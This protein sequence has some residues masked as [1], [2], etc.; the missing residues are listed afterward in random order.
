MLSS[1]SS[2]GGIVA[3][4]DFFVDMKILEWLCVERRSAMWCWS[5]KELNSVR[6]KIT[7]I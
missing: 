6:G 5:C 7:R 3:M 4:L 2:L 1:G